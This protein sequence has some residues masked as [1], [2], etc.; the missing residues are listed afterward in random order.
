MNVEKL[1]AIAEKCLSKSSP[2]AGISKEMLQDWCN[3]ATAESDRL[4]ISML[5]AKTKRYPRSNKLHCMVFMI[6]T[7]KRKRSIMQLVN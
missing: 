6:S 3:L 1:V 4:L 2:K 7:T 5:V